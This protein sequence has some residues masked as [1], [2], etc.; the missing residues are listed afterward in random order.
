MSNIDTQGPVW[1]AV[2]TALNLVERL[3]KGVERIADALEAQRVPED[4]TL[5]VDIKQFHGFDWSSIGASVVATDHDGVA[6]IRTANGRFANRRTNDKFGAEIWFSYATGKDTEGKNQYH[7]VVAFKQ[8]KPAEPMGRKAATVAGA[9]PPAPA[10]T[11]PASVSAPATTT[12]PAPVSAPATD[13]KPN[14][15]RTWLA[16]T[17]G[18]APEYDHAPTVRAVWSNLQ[19]NCEAHKITRPANQPTTLREAIE[20]CVVM[21]TALDNAHN[22]FGVAPAPAAED[23]AK[24]K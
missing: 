14:T 16:C 19:R 22:L 8:P 18:L 11:T 2:V 17:V 15:G 6:T 21:A 13:T 23:C 20:Q 24:L 9:P 3:T 4:E 1:G 10:T 5:T 7:K 12:T